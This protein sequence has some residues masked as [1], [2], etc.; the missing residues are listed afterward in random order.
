MGRGLWGLH[1]RSVGLS[2]LVRG[3]VGLVSCAVSAACQMAFSSG[4]TGS[5]APDMVSAVMPGMI[6]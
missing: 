1:Q 2:A 6:I 4:C 5:L 3:S